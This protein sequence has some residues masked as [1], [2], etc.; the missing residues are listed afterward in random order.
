MLC[1]LTLK[2]LYS[3][4]ACCCPIQAMSGGQ[5]TRLNNLDDSTAVI[6][7]WDSKLKIQKRY[8]VIPTGSVEIRVCGQ[9]SD[10]EVLIKDVL[11]LHY[12]KLFFIKRLILR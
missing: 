3:S 10:I 12:E 11:E 9:L 4:S 8:L 7:N 5:L 2:H 6:L 1:A